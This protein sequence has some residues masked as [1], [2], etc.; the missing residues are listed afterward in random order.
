MINIFFFLVY[1]LFFLWFCFIRYLLHLN[2]KWHPLSLLLLKIPYPIPPP[3]AHPSSHDFLICIPVFWIIQPSH[4]QGPL[5]SLISEMVIFCYICSWSRGTLHIY[6]LVGVLVPG[7][8]GS[9]SWYILL[10]L[11]QGC[12]PFQLLRSSL[13]LLHCGPSAQS[14]GWPWLFWSI[15]Q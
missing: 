4:D 6:A 3:S 1:I 12:T 8:S 15:F 10:F 11:L 7:S 9:T 14:I 5:L 13:Q 2:F